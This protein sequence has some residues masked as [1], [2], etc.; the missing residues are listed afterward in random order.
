[1]IA[2]TLTYPPSANKL[3][4]AVNGRQIKSAEY[5]AWLSENARVRRANPLDGP[6]ELQVVAT[7]PDKRRR[8]LDNLIKPIGDIIQ[9]LGFVSDDKHMRRLVAEW[10]EAEAPGVDITIIPLGTL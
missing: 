9:A 3:W 6:Y 1:M 10:G 8:D 4:R 7:A 2:C 5:R